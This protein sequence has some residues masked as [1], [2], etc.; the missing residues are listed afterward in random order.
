MNELYVNRKCRETVIY[1][2]S[3]NTTCIKLVYI[4]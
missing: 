3:F 4:L 1:K 2:L